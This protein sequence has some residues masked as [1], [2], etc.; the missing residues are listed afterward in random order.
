MLYL[1]MAL[2]AARDGRTGDVATHLA[3]ARLLAAHTGE[4]P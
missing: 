1:T 3:E 4:R 2:I